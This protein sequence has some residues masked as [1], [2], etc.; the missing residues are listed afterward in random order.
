MFRCILSHGRRVNVSPGNAYREL[1]MS[2]LLYYQ[3][4]I[5]TV[6][7]QTQLQIP[8]FY[9][10]ATRGD[11]SHEVLRG[12]QRLKRKSLD[13]NDN[14]A[15]RLVILT[16]PKSAPL[17][18]MQLARLGYLDVADHSSHTS[19]SGRFVGPGRPYAQLWGRRVHTRTPT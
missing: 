1:S 14:Q 11:R 15:V 13:R 17:S 9:R 12:S 5:S 19:G 8:I 4:S 6:E 16:L 7:P 18:L 10:S 3:S 2:M